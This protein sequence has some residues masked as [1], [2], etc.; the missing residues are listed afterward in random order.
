MN[1]EIKVKPWYL[2]TSTWV[3]IAT[4]AATIYESGLIPESSIG[5]KVLGLLVAAFVT[6]G[7]IAKRGMV[8]AATIKANALASASKSASENPTQPQP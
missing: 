2:S 5:Y 7:L 6:V 4:I 1:E 8:E 3:A